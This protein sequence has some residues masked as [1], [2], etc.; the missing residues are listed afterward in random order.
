MLPLALLA[1]VAATSQPSEDEIIVIGKRLSAIEV[2]ISRDAK[3]RLSCGL[4]GSS[5]NARIDQQLC[6]VSASC[7]RK[8][9]ESGEAVRACVQQRKAGLFDAFRRE[10][11][12]RRT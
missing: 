9:A 8:G 3:G 4:S 11:T 6:K 10:M 2:S 5:G 1:A 7:F 12:R